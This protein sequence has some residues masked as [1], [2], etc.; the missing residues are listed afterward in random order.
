MSDSTWPYDLSRSDR[1][2]RSTPTRLSPP[3]VQFLTKLIPQDLHAL[4]E[5]IPFGSQFLTEA[6]PIFAQI[7]A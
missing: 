1:T 7:R 3:G 5:S 2:Y 4:S 6:N